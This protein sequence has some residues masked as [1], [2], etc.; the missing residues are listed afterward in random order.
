[1]S[2]DRWSFRYHPLNRPGVLFVRQ[3]TGESSLPPLR[4]TDY[5][6]M[7][8]PGQLFVSKL[9]DKRR[10]GLEIVLQ[11]TL[12]RG[13]MGGLLDELAGIFANRAQGPLQHFYP[14]GTIRTAQAE[15]AAWQPVDISTGTGQG[16]VGTLY[17][18]VADFELADPYFYG[19]AVAVSGL[20]PASPT[21]LNVTDPGTVRGPAQQ[22]TLTL[23]LLGP[24][25]NP[26]IVNAANG[27]SVQC[28]VTVAAGTHLIIDCVAFTA[29]NDGVNAIANI[30]HSGALEFM[31]LE[32]GPNALAV[33][34]TGVSGATSL[35]VTFTPAYL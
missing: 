13:L 4:G 33:T 29:L 2:L 12:G 20:I 14:D 30:R 26:Q 19:P 10:T 9:A 1:M 32:P 17:A 3:M 24:I 15:V 31:V 8:V 22:G 16:G 28:L 23:D 21:T 25:S 18:G 7:G 34:G 6:T 11:D 5:T 35:T 27:L